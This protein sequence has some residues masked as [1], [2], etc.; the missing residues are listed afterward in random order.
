MHCNRGV[1]NEGYVAQGAKWIRDSGRVYAPTRRA[2]WQED[3]I[4][5]EKRT[6]NLFSPF[7]PFISYHL[8]S[9]LTSVNLFCSYRLFCV[10]RRPLQFNRILFWPCNIGCGSLWLTSC[11]YSSHLATYLAKNWRPKRRTEGPRRTWAW[12]DIRLA[13]G[14]RDPCHVIKHQTL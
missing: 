10:L 2:A 14:G 12:R 8:P 11:F 7:L 3:I 1:N 4:R 6:L 5:E 9:F 13:L